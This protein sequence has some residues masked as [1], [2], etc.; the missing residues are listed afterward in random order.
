MPFALQSIVIKDEWEDDGGMICDFRFVSEWDT[1]LMFMTAFAS[2]QDFLQIFLS[3]TPDASEYYSIDA[4]YRSKLE[5]DLGETDLQVNYTVNGKRHASIIE[6]K[7]DAQETI[8]QHGRYILRA[9][10]G[11]ERGEYS[12]YFLFILSP[13]KY[14]ELNNEAKKY[15]YFVS[16]EECLVY[17]EEK[18]DLFSQFCSQQ[19][20]DAFT[21]TKIK[22]ETK[23]NQVAVDSLR[24]YE[25]YLK[26]HYPKLQFGNN[27]K[28]GKVNGWWVK[29]NV[30]LRGAVIHHKTDM[31]FV[32]LS[33]AHGAEKLS[34]FQSIERWLHESGHKSITVVQTQK[35][36]TF[37][38]NVP[39]I[40][41]WEPYESWNMEDF[42]KCLDAEMELSQIADMFSAIRDIFE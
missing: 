37:R 39:V 33:I 30:P 41:M 12:D 9:E 31:G 21:S 38:I 13:Q 35:S 10:K 23:V 20:K 14:R 34:R 3:K 18:N 25:A 27:T 5:T 1:T 22:N 19:L 15:E 6:N 40:H 16:Y 42:K 24:K 26:N 32:D 11:K 28:S 2:D 8:N 17:F 36:A 7:I 29:I 4:V